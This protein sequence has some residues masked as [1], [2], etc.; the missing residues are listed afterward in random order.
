ME[1]ISC[2]WENYL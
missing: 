1:E 2:N